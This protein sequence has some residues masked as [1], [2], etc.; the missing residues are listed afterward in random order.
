MQ[1]EWTWHNARSNWIFPLGFYCIL[2]SVGYGHPFV[3]IQSHW[4]FLDKKM[5][6]I[7]QIQLDWLPTSHISPPVRLRLCSWLRILRWPPR[8]RRC[9]RGRPCSRTARSWRQACCCLGSDLATRAARGQP[10][11]AQVVE[12]CCASNSGRPPPWPRGHA[13]SLA[14]CRTAEHSCVRPAVLTSG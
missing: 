7:I 12:R 3:L 1:W 8:H 11:P 10:T 2:D 9:H 4:L 14:L 6:T 5:I 13:S